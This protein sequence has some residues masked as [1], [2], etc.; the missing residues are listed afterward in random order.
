MEIYEVLY[1]DQIGFCDPGD[2][3]RF[4]WSGDD[5]TA[6]IDTVQIRDVDFAYGECVVTGF[7]EVLN[8]TLEYN[9]PDDTEV[10][11]LGG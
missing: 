5:G 3:V 11:V 1:K 10:E 9:M 6:Y 2:I 4:V 8:E 7:S